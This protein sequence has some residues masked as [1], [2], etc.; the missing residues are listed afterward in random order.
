MS[1]KMT[2][3]ITGCDSGMGYSIA[4][5]ALEFGDSVVVTARDTANVEALL[6]GYPGRAFGYQLDVTD[7][8]AIR[9]VVDA[10]E[11]A[12][13]GID[14]LVNNAGFGLLGTAEET[15]PDEYRPLFEVNFFGTV[16][17]TR[18]LLPCMR[19]RGRGHIINM[20]SSGGYAASPGFPFYAASKFAVEGFSESV[21]Q[22][23][24]VF[25]IKLT[26]IEPGSVRTR[27]AGASMQRAKMTIPTYKDSAAMLTISR[28]AG[29][30]GAQP[31]DPRRVA[32][33]LIRITRDPAPPLR[34]PL[35]QDGVERVEKKIAS[36]MATFAKW[37]AVSLSTAFG[38]QED[39]LAG[40][41]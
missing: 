6:K 23:V 30:D 4:E 40:L 20:S 22:E 7:A 33:V 3:F 9:R 8:V 12:T 1:M 31:E 10:A 21:A 5:R 16:E 15:S 19:Q 26:L 25:G 13:G 24:A 39:I 36:D 17:V 37:R 27:F 28:M 38:N 35:G 34:L 14:V 41:E 2:W 11:Q 32:E 29:R 18:A